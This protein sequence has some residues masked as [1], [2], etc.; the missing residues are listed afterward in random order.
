MKRRLSFLRQTV[1]AGV[2]LIAIG[3]WLLVAAQTV[4]LAR[5]AAILPP[6]TPPT[7]VPA[8]TPTTPARALPTAA[9]SALLADVSTVAGETP[10]QF[11]PKTGR[12]ISAW[13][14]NSFDAMN[15]AS[16]IENADILDEVSPFWYG[17]NADGQLYHDPIDTELLELA[18]SKNVLVIPTIHNVVAGADPVPAIL[19]NPDRRSR[20][21]QAIVDEVMTRNYD[22][23]DIDYESLSPNLREEYTAFIRELS[24]ELKAHDKMLTIAVHAKACDQCGLGGY[25]D[26]PALGE[27]VDRLRIMTYD[28]SWRGSAPGPIAPV[29]WVEEVIA[30]AKQV[31]PPS[32]VIVGVPFYGYNWPAGGG[33]ATPQLWTHIN[34]LIQSRQLAVNLQESNARGLVQESWITYNGRQAWFATSRS[35][36]AK[37]ALVQQHDLAGIAIWRLGGE[38]PTNWSVIRTKLVQDPFESQRMINRALPDH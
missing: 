13:M 33:R 21:V 38:D 27:L 30:Y 9:P 12:Y 24:A 29:Y 37:L 34:D 2:L 22:G 36:D 1:V 28:Y 31:V 10:Q 6:L 25:Q 8:A 17:T 20:H 15:R 11:H 18:R 14:P 7:A 16:F 35:L 5:E 4:G 3:A 32:K 19:S 23:I 26:W